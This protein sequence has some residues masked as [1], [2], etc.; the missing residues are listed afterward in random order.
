MSDNEYILDK[1]KQLDTKST[2]FGYMAVL[3]GAMSM[4]IG[5]VPLARDFPSS[6]QTLSYL[7][8]VVA[9]LLFI[10]IVGYVAYTIK[11]YFT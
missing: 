5:G 3:I 8:W 7:Y 4:I 10:V 6:L 9:A 1:I 2:L 11:I